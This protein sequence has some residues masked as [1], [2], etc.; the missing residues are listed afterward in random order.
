MYIKTIKKTQ[1]AWKSTKNLENRM[2]FGTKT[3]ITVNLYCEPAV[4]LYGEVLF[5]NE[6]VKRV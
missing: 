4:Q 3:Y 1:K 2:K 5:G 6:V